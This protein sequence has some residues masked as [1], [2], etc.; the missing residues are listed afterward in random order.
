M[1][2][3]I[4]FFDIEERNRLNNSLLL[5]I[6]NVSNLAIFKDKMEFSCK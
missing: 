6:A 5:T 3:F 1:D 2:E 4:F